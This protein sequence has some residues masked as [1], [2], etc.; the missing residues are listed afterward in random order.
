M[1]A[2]A[3]SPVKGLFVRRSR[4]G[5]SGCEATAGPGGQEAAGEPWPW[6]AGPGAPEGAIPGA[7]GRLRGPSPAV[8]GHPQ[9]PI[10]V[11]S[12]VPWGA[13]AFGITVPH[14]AHLHGCRA[15]QGACPAPT[16]GV[17]GCP[18]LWHHSS[19]GQTIPVTLGCHWVPL[20]LASACHW[21]PILMVSEHPWVLPAPT[22]PA[23]EPPPHAGPPTHA[24]TQGHERCQSC[25]FICPMPHQEV[26]TTAAVAAMLSSGS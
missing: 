12:S 26:A 18:S 2:M 11:V 21:V 20:P 3:G 16:W 14:G 17:F 19:S 23:T 9:G 1:L 8:T 6:P 10:P 25:G 13:C 5:G 22:L 24:P 7:S 4:A 15:P